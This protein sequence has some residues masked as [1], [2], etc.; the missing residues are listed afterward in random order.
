MIGAY[1]VAWF[2]D[3]GHAFVFMTKAEIE[4]IRDRYSRAANRE[5]SVWK[6]DTAAMWK[7][8]VTRQLCKWLPLS[9]ELQRA[10][11]IDLEAEAGKQDLGVEIT[12]EDEIKIPAETG[13]ADTEKDLEEKL[14]RE[15][16]QGEAHPPT[17]RTEGEPGDDAGASEEENERAAKI[18]RL[19]KTGFT[20]FL[21]TITPGYWASAHGVIRA[22]IKKKHQSPKIF[23]C[24]FDP[25]NPTAAFEKKEPTTEPPVKTADPKNEPE[26]GEGENT[27]GEAPQAP[28]GGQ[29]TQGQGLDPRIKVKCPDRDEDQISVRFCENVCK[30]TVGCPSY[31]A[32]LND[33]MPF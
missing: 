29:T 1:A 3:G 14:G 19:K 13:T 25:A 7:K 24:D 10:V 22:A 28:E 30:K 20:E 32:A 31:E 17:T 18:S 6:T 15:P 16:D 2:K 9:P 8:T 4:D 12:P 21:K 26:E 11:G 33:N 27:T 5:D 23:G